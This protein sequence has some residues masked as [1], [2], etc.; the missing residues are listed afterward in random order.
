MKTLFKNSSNKALSFGVILIFLLLTGFVLTASKIFAGWFSAR[1]MTGFAVF[2]FLYGLLIG[3]SVAKSVEEDIWKNIVISSAITGVLLGL[4]LVVLVLVLGNL[5]AAQVSVRD[6]LPNL[7]PAFIKVLLYEGD[8][9]FLGA[10]IN[11]SI[12]LVS[13]I[14]GGALSKILSLSDIKG[15]ISSGEIIT[16]QKGFIERIKNLV[17]EKTSVKYGLYA[18]GFVLMAII[19]QLMNE[20][21]NLNLGTIGIYILM[22]I[23]LNLVVGTAG[24]LDLGFVAFYA[25]GAY[26]VG[27]LTAPKPLGILMPFWPA[28]LIGILVAIVFGFLIGI[29]VVRLRGDYLA[30]V[31]LGFGEITRVLIQSD[32]LERWTGGPQGVKDRYQTRISVYHPDIH[33]PGFFYNK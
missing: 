15:K 14:A 26:T 32:T 19:P 1:D 30:I 6:Y 17:E 2:L 31:T 22:G 29:P 18:L 33:Y 21:W 16:E 5:R 13:T 9:I 28:F 8:S 20:S 23:G 3:R 27:L 12:V 10:I 4:L 24:L 25:I 11:F 7:S